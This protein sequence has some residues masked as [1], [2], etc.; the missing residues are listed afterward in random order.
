MRTYKETHPSWVA[1][2]VR[3][4]KVQ[5]SRLGAAGDAPGAVVPCALTATTT[6]VKTMKSLENMVMMV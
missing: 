1:A 5:A 6:A 3:H 4:C 2:S